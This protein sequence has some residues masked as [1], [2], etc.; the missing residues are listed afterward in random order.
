MSFAPTVSSS[1]MAEFLGVTRRL[2][3]AHGFDNTVAGFN[4]AHPVPLK[5]IEAMKI[6]LDA[7]PSTPVM[8]LPFRSR[9]MINAAFDQLSEHVKR[10]SLA[11]WLTDP[12]ITTTEVVALLDAALEEY[13]VRP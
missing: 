2:L 6:A 8:T 3:Q 9:W 5:L 1:D 4:P 10:P 11:A 13:G 7:S 12:Q